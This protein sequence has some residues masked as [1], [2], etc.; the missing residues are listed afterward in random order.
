[1][2]SI[3][4]I[5]KR[6]GV[7]ISTVSRILNGTARVKPDKKRAVREAIEYYKYEPN[8]FARG[9][10]RQKSDMIGL[11]LPSLGEGPQNLSD[12][13][14]GIIRGISNVVSSF[15]YSLI[16]LFDN[17]HG[18]VTT[19]EFL[20]KLKTK[21]V[22]G[23]IFA[24][25]PSE[26]SSR[27]CIKEIEEAAYPVVYIGQRFE[28]RIRNVYAQFTS[29]TYASL[30]YL[31][32]KGHR[33]ILLVGTGLHAKMLDEVRAKAVSKLEDIDL[34]VVL[35]ADETS[36]EAFK[37]KLSGYID[38]GLDAVAGIGTE[39]LPFLYGCLAEAGLSVPEDVSVIATEHKE[40][41]GLMF[42]PETTC[43]YIPA[44]DMGRAAAELLINAIN[45]NGQETPTVELESVLMERDS[46][47][48]V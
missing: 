14:L 3:Y 21:K 28:D 6:A 38:Q 27:E 11:F 17:N 34:K 9:L 8:Q 32:S 39:Q 29:Y 7:S 16:L 20:D 12:Y 35:I 48:S 2:A 25:L 19:P 22:D 24:A 41:A 42:F 45:G 4:D 26:E 13:Y 31:H 43:V 10:V 23:I 1:M 15:G 30:S 33:H 5:A 46:V 18:Q 37:E 40:G 36:Y 47:K 44:V